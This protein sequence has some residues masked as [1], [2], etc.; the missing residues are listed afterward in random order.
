MKLRAFTGFISYFHRSLYDRLRA[1]LRE[2]ILMLQAMRVSH[3]PIRDVN[4]GPPIEQWPFCVL[5]SNQCI[6]LAENTFLLTRP[7]LLP[8]FH[9]IRGLTPL[10][11][12]TLFARRIWTRIL[13]PCWTDIQPSKKF[14]VGSDG[15]SL[16]FAD[17]GLETGTQ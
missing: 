14:H 11:S 3:T 8:A 10:Y 6:E 1:T 13:L 15:A 17:Q 5:S 7:S 2:A 4:S 9:E 12:V 16:G